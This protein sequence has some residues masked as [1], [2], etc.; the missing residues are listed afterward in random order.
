VLA[1]KHLH[2]E[3]EVERTKNTKEVRAVPVDPF[4]PSSW[5]SFVFFVFF[6]VQSFFHPPKNKAGEIAGL[7]VLQDAFLGMH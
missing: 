3:H 5:L 2:E 4:W 6:V 7:V 1:K